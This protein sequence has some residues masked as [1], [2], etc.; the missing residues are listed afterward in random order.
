MFDTKVLLTGIILLG[1]LCPVAQNQKG[2][3]I[4]FHEHK[5]DLGEINPQKYQIKF[6][7]HNSGDRPLVITKVMVSCS[8]ASPVWSKEPLQPGVRDTLLVYFDPHN[9]IGKAASSIF[10]FSNASEKPE[11]VRIEAIV[12]PK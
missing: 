4:C 6:V 8:C 5:C 9:K 2:A 10:V 12:S 1:C 3:A 7:Y 11:I